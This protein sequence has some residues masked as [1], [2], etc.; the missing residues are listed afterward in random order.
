MAKGVDGIFVSVSGQ[1]VTLSHDKGATTNHDVDAGAT[2][3]LNNKAAKLSDLK[4]GDEITLSGN[5]A[6]TVDA[7][8]DV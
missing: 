1:V 3:A 5:P 6:V 2:V 8:R 7:T 4:A